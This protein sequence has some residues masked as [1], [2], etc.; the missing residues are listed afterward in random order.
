[1][2]ASAGLL[3]AGFAQQVAPPPA[4]PPVDDVAQLEKYVVTGS[5]IKGGNGEGSLPVQTIT[6]AEMDRLGITS[7]EQMIMDLN[8]NGNGLDNLASNADVTAGAQR[9]NNG[10]TAANLRMQGSGATLVLFNGRRVSSAG[11]NQSVVDLNQIPL[12]AI[13]RVEVLKDG[14]SSIYGTDAVGG[15]INFITK[16]NYQGLAASTSADVTQEGGGNIYR[17]SLVGGWG[18][19]EKNKFN[20]W[21]SLSISDSKMLRGDQ[22]SWN[23]TFYPNKGLSPDTRGTPIA[24][25]FAIGSATAPIPTV[26]TGAGQTN[27]STGPLDPT[28]SALR[29]NGINILDLPTNTAGYA[30]APGMGP[31]DEVLWN[32][33]AS[34]YGSAWDTGRAM[35]LQQPVKNTNGVVR[36]TYRWA[37]H[38]DLFFEGMAGRSKSTKS[39]SPS[40]WSTSATATTTALDGKTVVH[41]PAFD[42]LYPSTAPDYTRVFNALVAYFPELAP[43]FGAPMAFRWRSVPLGNRAYTTTSDSWRAMVGAQGPLGFLADWDYRTGISR[44]QNKANSKLVSGFVFTQPFANL[45]K[46]GVVDPFSYTQTPDAMAAIAKTSAN[47]VTLY[48]GTYR[49]DEADFSASGKVYRLPAGDIKAAIGAD[50][51]QE[52]YLF[53]GDNRQNLSSGDAL[54]LNA[55]FDNGLATNGTLKR[56][57]KAAYAE[58]QVPILHGLDFD[59]SGRIDQYTGFGSTK[60]PKLSLRYSPLPSDKLIFRG[61]YSTGFRVPTFKQMFDP[62]TVSPLAST[63]LK[64][65]ATGAI[66]TPNS[67]QTLFGGKSDLQPEKAKMYSAGFVVQPNKYITANVDWW[68]VDRTNTIQSFGVTDLLANYSLFSDRFTRNPD[69]TIA[70]IDT[71]WVNSGETRT[72]GIEY[73]LKG[74]MNV[75]NGA[76]LSAGFDLSYLL[77][78][79]SRLLPTAP[80]DNEEINQFT[81]ASD[82]GLRWKHTAYITYRKG[83]WSGTINQL[84]RNSYVDAVLPGVAAGLVH[85][86]Q[87]SP[88]VKAYDIFGLSVS[89]NGF[90]HTTVIM[91]IKNLFNQH[92][93]FSAVYDTNTGAGSDWEPRIADPRDRSL[94]MRIDYKF[95]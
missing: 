84:Y 54:I 46:T 28:N 60:N 27:T 88:T 44:A 95:Y 51:R 63:G 25:L 53:T 23:G 32:S 9:G 92:P 8:I 17:Y 35:V 37:E 62:V 70:T 45:I 61:S 69:G 67:V 21:S 34:K 86:P 87:W 3:P 77:D 73:G 49:T 68:L 57:I 26:L 29:V 42:L 59:A 14:A 72:A 18:D 39:F 7:V 75:G 30:N 90:E 36:G 15:V 81:R 85:P 58:L 89:Y 71:R 50:W 10:V 13:E 40:Q 66:I 41:N 33:A 65:P 91:G 64:D 12:A 2:V 11:L 80:W 79:R 24:T 83:H 55:P 4:N 82:I 31:Y 22:R 78:K 52:S 43:N 74:Y 16:E 38:Q 94:T 93:P 19:L 6:P 56:T 1:M 47:G 5:L 48:G 76:T 20:V